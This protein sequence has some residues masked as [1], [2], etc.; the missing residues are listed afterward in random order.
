MNRF[1]IQD[2]TRISNAT[3]IGQSAEN[4]LVKVTKF[5]IDS[6]GNVCH[7]DH[8]SFNISLMISNEYSAYDASEK[9]S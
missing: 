4:F 8:H 5:V 6:G 2:G 3:E 7:F 9:Q 1:E